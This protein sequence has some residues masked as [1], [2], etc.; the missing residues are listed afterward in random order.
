MGEAATIAGAASLLI[1]TA[2]NE[3]QEAEGSPHFINSG[4]QSFVKLR[5][6]PKPSNPDIP[7]L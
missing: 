4:G 6:E 3:I 1:F 7:V 2:V 5:S